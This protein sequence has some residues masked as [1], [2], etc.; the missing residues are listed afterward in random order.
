MIMVL[1]IIL[2]VFGAI[3]TLLFIMTLICFLLTF[4][5]PKRKKLAPDEYEI[6]KGDIYEVFR[7]DIIGWTKDI[8]SMPRDDVSITSHDGLTLRG[9][10]YESKMA[11]YVR[12]AH[13]KMPFI[14]ANAKRE[15]KT[16]VPSLFVFMN[17]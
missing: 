2:A 6:P 4:Y 1:Y 14:C 3:I 9:K 17:L 16:E 5:S 10:Y 13:C 8:R 15:S 11:S 7:E 12:S